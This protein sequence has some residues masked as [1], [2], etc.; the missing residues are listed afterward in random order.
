MALRHF[1]TMHCE[2]VVW[3]TGL[4]GRL[5]AT[6]IVQPLC[7]V[8]THIG[9]DHQEWLGS[10]LTSIASEKA[11]IIKAHTP[12]VLGTLEPEA[13]AIMVHQCKVMDSPCYKA[14]E[15]SLP[16]TVKLAWRGLINGSTPA[17]PLKSL[18]FLNIS[19]LIK[20]TDSTSHRK[21]S[22]WADSKNAYGADG[23]SCWMSPT[24]QT[25]FRLCRTLKHLRR[26]GHLHLVFGSLSDKDCRKACAIWPPSLTFGWSGHKVIVPW[27]RGHGGIRRSLRIKDLSLVMLLGILEQT[28]QALG[29]Q[30]AALRSSPVLLGRCCRAFMDPEGDSGL[31]VALTNGV[32]TFKSIG[33]YPILFAGLSTPNSRILDCTSQGNR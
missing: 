7:S 30:K 12:V 8:I 6:N 26:K 15:A 5:D 23:R 25:P 4:G 24:T 9:M 20:A 32:P 19:F 3:E 28:M 2:L 10:S 22:R 21:H 31:E 29:K 1:A 17:S 33:K 14:T 27:L 16:P 11:G 18:K 13:E